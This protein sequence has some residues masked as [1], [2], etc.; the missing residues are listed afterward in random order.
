MNVEKAM[1]F[2][3]QD[4]SEIISYD[5]DGIPLSV[6]ERHLSWYPDRKALYHWHTDL[7]FLRISEG[8]M[9][10]RINRK[11]ITL[12]QGDCLFI[13][14]RQMHCGCSA[15]QDDCIFTCLL[16]HPCLFPGNEAMNQ[17]YVQPVLT[18]PSLEYLHFQAG[19]PAGSMVSQVL[20]RILQIKK[21]GSPSYEMEAIGAITALWGSLLKICPMLPSGH[22]EPLGP[23]DL[24]IQRNMVSYIY[25]HFYEKIS[26]ADIVAAGHVSRNK[27]CAVF[28]RY[29]QQSPVDFLIAYRLKMSCGLLQTTQKPITEIALSCGF[30]HPSYYSKAFREH[31]GCTPREYRNRDSIQY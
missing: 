31:F 23:S 9:A 15:N 29:L 8:T 3:M 16:F 7:E 11:R 27:C 21:D 5:R 18:N 20:D 26:L 4:A 24:I 28:Q 1:T 30:N 12:N 6:K 17:Q 22:L 25:Q 19:S 14:S 13:N 2:V 10:Y